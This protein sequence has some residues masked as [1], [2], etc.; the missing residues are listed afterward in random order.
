MPH[1]TAVVSQRSTSGH[2][3]RGKDAALFGVFGMLAP[4]VVVFG[5]R[6]LASE[7]AWARA[8]RLIKIRA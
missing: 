6:V 2:F 4:A 5:L 8:E 3:Y 7:T 1:S